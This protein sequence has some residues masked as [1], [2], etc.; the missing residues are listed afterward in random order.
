MMK[1]LQP[2]PQCIDCLMSLAKNVVALADP[3]NQG[4]IEKAERISRNVLAEAVHNESSS[5]QIAN[6]I[7]REISQ[8]TGIA[9]PYADF[10]AREMDQARK[11]F[12]QLQARVGEDLRSRVKL[13][14]LGNSLD[15]FKNPAR[16]LAEIPHQFDNGISFYYDNIDQLEACLAKSPQKALYLTDNAGEIYFDL[17]LYEYLKQCCRKIYLVVKGGPSLNDFTRVELKSAELEDKFDFVADTGSDGAG[18]DWENVSGEFRDL[19]DSADLIVSK[20]MANFETL[21]PKSISAPGFYLFKV[22][23][24]PIQ[25]YVQAPVDSFLAIWKGGE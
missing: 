9:D 14:A 17:P 20:G 5:P 6:R 7:L 4:L 19:L 1:P 22:K 3:E 8:L 11:I 18:I 10:K 23:C 13:A 25:N 15:F 12:S 21:Y 24:E 2:I 16:A